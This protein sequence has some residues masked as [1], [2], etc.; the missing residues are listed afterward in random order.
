[1]RALQ[2]ITPLVYELVEPTTEQ[3]TVIDVLWGSLGVIGAVAGF[4]VVL[5][6][7]LA[8]VMIGLQRFRGRGKLT[9]RGSDSVRLGL[10]DA[11]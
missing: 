11:D 7:L 6:M 1:M 2:P 3:T 4:A 10:G 9:G 8:G 5:G